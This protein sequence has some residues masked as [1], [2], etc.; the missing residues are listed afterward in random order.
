MAR[1]SRRSLSITVIKSWE[2]VCVREMTL[3]PGSDPQHPG[4][5]AERGLGLPHP[6]P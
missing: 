3:T 6:A 4:S 2:Q 1:I 5:S